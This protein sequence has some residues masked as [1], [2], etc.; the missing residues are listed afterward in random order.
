MVKA[1]RVKCTI[2]NKFLPDAPEAEKFKPFCS[3]RCATIDLGRWLGEEY[4]M[5]SEEEAEEAL[6][7]PENDESHCH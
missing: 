1:I 3:P 4:R 2:C 7:S 5:A 6:I